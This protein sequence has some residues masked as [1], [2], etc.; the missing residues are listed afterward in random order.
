MPFDTRVVLVLLAVFIWSC[1]GR[2]VGPAYPRPRTRLARDLRA[3]LTS[4][5][6]PETV[7][8]NVTLFL[9]SV[10]LDFQSGTF[11]ANGWLGMVWTDP[12][13]TWDPALYGGLDTHPITGEDNWVPPIDLTNSKQLQFSSRVCLIGTCR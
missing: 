8:L 12:R 3:N 5:R 2:T 7:R 4:I 1:T 9:T 6:R 10:D 11:L 13:M